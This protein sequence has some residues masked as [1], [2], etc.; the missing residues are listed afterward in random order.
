MSFRAW[1]FG[2]TVACLVDVAEFLGLVDASQFAG[3]CVRP[4]VVRADKSVLGGAGSDDNPWP[5]VGSGVQ[6]RLH[7]S[8]VLADKQNRDVHQFFGVIGARAGKLA[9]V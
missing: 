7:D 3:T 8:V 5:S 1:Y 2:Q 4:C 6:E 9:L